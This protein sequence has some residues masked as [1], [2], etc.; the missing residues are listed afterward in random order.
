[1]RHI[2]IFEK[3]YDRIV[4]FCVSGIMAFCLVLIGAYTDCLNVDGS[5]YWL[6]YSVT[7]GILVFLV[8]KL[9][10]AEKI[11]QVF[12]V[13]ERHF[14]YHT[15][16]WFRTL[17]FVIAIVCFAIAT[18]LAAVFPAPPFMGTCAAISAIGVLVPFW[19]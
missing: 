14:A 9:Q 7:T 19:K 2:S 18:W 15:E 12:G 8:R 11:V 16:Q 17:V 13:S 4:W 5:D 3:G 1:M 6:Y 10:L